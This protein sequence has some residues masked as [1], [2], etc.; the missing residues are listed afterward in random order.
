MCLLWVASTE[1]VCSGTDYKTRNFDDGYWG[2]LSSSIFPESL[3]PT[4]CNMKFTAC[5]KEESDLFHSAYACPVKNKRVNIE[6]LGQFDV[7][8]CKK[9]RPGDPIC[10]VD[11][12]LSEAAWDS[13]FSTD[14]R[15][16][17]TS[18]AYMQ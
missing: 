5:Q 9:Q 17:T 16:Q 10:D 6:L 15:G 3:A 2:L 11:V 1:S 8:S 7:D 13:T 18:T 12:V 14:A 4:W